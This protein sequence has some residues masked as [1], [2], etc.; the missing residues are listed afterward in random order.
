MDLLIAFLIFAAT[1]VACLIWGAGYA[2]L[3]ALSVG[4]F[5]FYAVARL[6]GFEPRDLA[7][8]MVKGIKRAMIVVRIFVLI[9]VLTALWRSGGTITFFVYHGIRLIP[10]SLFLVAGF[11]LTCLLG[12]ALGT[13]FGVTGTVGVILMTL[14]RSGGVPPAL[15][16]GAVL[17]GAYFGDR[18]APASSCANLVAT[19]TGTKL[20]DNI[21]RMLK[22]GLIPLLVTAA[23]Y[24]VLSPRY[25]L[26]AG[27]AGLM[28]L[29]AQSFDL[30]WLCAAPA[31]IMLV[32]P[33]C[34]VNV[35]L[36]MALSSAAAFALSVL[37]QDQP[38]FETLLTCLRGYQA[39]E[40]TLAGILSGGGLLSMANVSGIII[41]SSTYSGIFEGTR[42][43]EGLQ[44]KLLGWS[45]K[46]TCCGLMV[47]TS[48]VTTCV[49]CNQTIGTMMIQQLLG[50]VYEKMGKPKEDL[51]LDMANT[52]VVMVALCPWCIACAVPLSML[53]VGTEAIP[54]AVF[55]WLLPLW[56]LCVRLWQDKKKPRSN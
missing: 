13:S 29:L 45:K 7:R 38:L 35:R 32:L 31:V 50:P 46:L 53:G 30:S 25:P 34:K 49:F 15:M 43:L 37:L 12:Y 2:M 26:A 6:R 28:S 8:M 56:W 55:L 5:C 16:A 51:A 44:E 20:Y 39:Q 42:M 19:V 47:V 52:L 23:V 33:M 22:S 14:A 9:G 41:L 40:P 24:A 21:P 11:A 18:T 4:L 3:V 17:S 27:E 1:M 48:T 10:P 54:L 36:A